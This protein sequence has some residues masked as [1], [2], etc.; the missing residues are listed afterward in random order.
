MLSEKTLLVL[1][2]I[3]KV[4]G[5]PWILVW[6]EGA[7][8]LVVYLHLFLIRGRLQ[9]QRLILK[10]TH[11]FDFV[12]KTNDISILPM[13]FQFFLI[14]LVVEGFKIALRAIGV[15][16]A[17]RGYRGSLLRDPSF[18]IVAIEARHAN[19]S[20][21][22]GDELFIVGSTENL[23]WWCIVATVHNQ[24]DWGLFLNNTA[25]IQRV[26]ARWWCLLYYFFV[27]WGYWLVLQVR[28]V[29]TASVHIWVGDI[30]LLYI[31]ICF[32][33]WIL[34]TLP[35]NSLIVPRLIVISDGHDRLV[36]RVLLWSVHISLRLLPRILVLSLDPQPLITRI[37]FKLRWHAAC[38]RIFAHLWGGVGLARLAYRGEHGDGLR[39]RLVELLVPTVFERARRTVAVLV[40]KLWVY[41]FVFLRRGGA[42]RRHGC[43]NR[44]C[45]LLGA[46]CF[47]VLG[48]SQWG[49][50][51]PLAAREVG[52]MVLTALFDCSDAET[53]FPPGCGA[54]LRIWDNDLIGDLAL[55][56][57][58]SL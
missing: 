1:L 4:M 26:V 32:K 16:T 23:R 19:F 45:C 28:L 38:H 40:V 42:D 53:M 15:S 12:K 18:T 46:G 41:L 31:C 33:T 5:A 35:D 55:W 14:L 25:V 47:G 21:F 51:Q 22:L 2:E 6:F 39:A 20:Y 57:S 9:V 7:N 50:L 43:G 34:P 56:R 54:D 13:S 29:V 36:G 52:L 3:A 11:S 17:L 27:F 58:R 8:I 10:F 44:G 37:L 49:Y 30:L 24:R 48:S